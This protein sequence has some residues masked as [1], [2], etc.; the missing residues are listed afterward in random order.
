MVIC[1]QVRGIEGGRS[2]C[3]FDSNNPDVI[4]VV[5]ANGQ[6]MT[7]S[8]KEPGECKRLTQVRSCC[9]QLRGSR[10]EERK[11]VIRL[12]LLVMMRLTSQELL[13]SATRQQE[14]GEEG[15][16]T[17]E[18]VGD[19]E[20]DTQVRSCCYQLRGSKKEERK[21]VVRLKLLVMISEDD[22]FEL[23]YNNNYDLD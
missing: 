21:E 17:A 20:I 14:G 2:I 12:K 10:K 8:F 11:E 18:A 15:S 4:V 9:Y 19:D 23:I 3:G 5:C 6:V 16:N 13:L 1:T 22:E 7:S